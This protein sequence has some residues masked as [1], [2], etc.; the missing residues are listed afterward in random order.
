MMK[1]DEVARLD[2]CFNRASNDEQMFVLLQRDKA[3][4]ETIR[5]WVRERIRIG[6]NNPSDPEI[7]EALAC[8]LRMEARK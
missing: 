8:A 4:P 7:I 1:C 6:K 3:A 5:F 2:S